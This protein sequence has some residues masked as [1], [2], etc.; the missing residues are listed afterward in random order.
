[1]AMTRRYNFLLMMRKNEVSKT[2]LAV[3][4]EKVINRPQL[5]LLPPLWGK[6][7]WNYFPGWVT[8][9]E[10]TQND[11]VP[12]DALF[13]HIL[14]RVPDP[15]CPICWKSDQ[16]NQPD[17]KIAQYITKAIKE[18]KSYL[19]DPCRAKKV[20]RI[21]IDGVS[22]SACTVAGV[23]APLLKCALNNNFKLVVRVNTKD[24][25]GLKKELI[26]KW[27][28]R[29]TLH[30]IL[31][32]HDASCESQ[33]LKELI[34]RVDMKMEERWVAEY[35]ATFSDVQ[36][37]TEGSVSFLDGI[38]KTKVSAIS[39]RQQQVG[40]E[41]CRS[42]LGLDTKAN[43][44]TQKIR[45]FAYSKVFDES[46][47][48]RIRPLAWER[49]EV[50]WAYLDEM[51]RGDVL[52]FGLDAVTRYG[53][54]LRRKI[55]GD[56][57]KGE[58]VMSQRWL[59]YFLSR[60]EMEVV[61]MLQNAEVNGYLV[62]PHHD[63]L[64]KLPELIK[65]MEESGLLLRK[66]KKQDRIFAYSEVGKL[67]YE[68]IGERLRYEY[69]KHDE[70]V[71]FSTPEQ[72][73]GSEQ[74]NFVEE[75]FRKSSLDSIPKGQLV[76]VLEIGVGVGALTIPVADFLRQNGWPIEWDGIDKDKEKIA[77]YGKRLEEDKQRFR[78]FSP[79]RT[80]HQRKYIDD[81]KNVIK[82]WYADVINDLVFENKPIREISDKRYHLIFMPSFLFHVT[83]RRDCIKWASALLEP[84]GT[85]FLGYPS[86]AWLG[87][88]LGPMSHFDHEEDSKD[89]A[90]YAGFWQNWMPE[91]IRMDL[92]FSRPV[93]E[94]SRWLDGSFVELTQPMV[95]ISPDTL[96]NIM[97]EQDFSFA[98]T[99]EEMKHSE[100][101]VIPLLVDQLD[102]YRHKVRI[103]L[104]DVDIRSSSDSEPLF[105]YTWSWMK[106]PSEKKD[107]NGEVV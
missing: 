61:E 20:Q 26:E 37:I 89:Y 45:L 55:P 46:T 41:T 60:R 83:F 103:R 58:L 90:A 69:L 25:D 19:S 27:G 33:D 2:G 96:Y 5:R 3:D 105:T 77:F 78:L 94:Y 71:R 88:M 21:V 9:T 13:E 101:K 4:I 93:T 15:R 53:Q 85:I 18:L 66:K 39:L 102:D 73:R 67:F 100:E 106:K 86:G 47:W 57:L 91:H 35:V 24:P 40:C 75:L 87:G 29:P 36:C 104:R 51:Y 42:C 49:K 99:P 68:E 16:E 22:A 82:L 72:S 84:G 14:V 64:L 31:S 80:I 28:N 7:A 11:F 50:D 62:L 70:R 52:G 79:N 107:A 10:E 48:K 23:V 95:R 30:L 76:R 65:D 1:M 74:S 92:Y 97:C 34:T 98:A 12:K 63:Y 6:E 56:D 81:N 54:M 44:L 59:K 32:I 38:G 8:L 43:R 17:G